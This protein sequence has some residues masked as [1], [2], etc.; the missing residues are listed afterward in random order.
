MDAGFEYA[1][2]IM[3]FDRAPTAWPMPVQKQTHSPLIHLV[4][5]EELARRL[6][7]GRQRRLTLVQAPV[8]FGKTTLVSQW[9]GR[10][11]SEGVVVAWVTVHEDSWTPILL[12]R[13]IAAALTE[14]GIGVE[15]ASSLIPGRAEEGWRY[16]LEALIDA[17]VRAA[18]PIVIFLDQYEHC[19]IPDVDPAI[20]QLLS[21]LPQGVHVAI[22]TRQRPL[23]PIAKLYAEGQVTLV[24]A[25]ELR[26]SPAETSELLQ[27][28]LSPDSI[29][30]VHQLTEGWVV[31]VQLVRLWLTAG[32]QPTAVLDALTDPRQEI[33]HFLAEQ[34]LR[35]LPEDERDFL[36]Q[37]SFLDGFS[38]ALSDFVRQ[39]GDSARFLDAVGH[40]YPLVSAAGSGNASIRVHPLLRAEAR[41]L[42]S[43]RSAA[44]IAALQRRAAE[45]LSAHG[46]VYSAMQHAIA[47]GDT[48]M[49]ADIF[50]RAGALRLF[51]SQG[52]AQLERMLALLPD[53][54][55][56]H[57][58]R[59]VLAHIAML[60]F[61]GKRAEARHAYA[62]LA[63]RTDNFTRGS[64][65]EE[66]RRLRT[67]SL[68]VQMF[69]VIFGDE[70]ISS[71][72]LREF[73]QMDLDTEDLQLR[74]FIAAFLAVSYLQRG[75]LAKAGDAV[76]TAKIIFNDP[77]QSSSSRSAFPIIYQGMLAQIGGH[78][79][80]SLV[81]LD[82]AIALA[83]ETRGT[84]GNVA[85]LMGLSLKAEV[86]L[87]LGH[88]QSAEALL[89]RI[90][91]EFDSTT[92]WFD[93]YAP[94]MRTRYGIALL[95]GGPAE[96]ASAV[97]EFA[98]HVPS[99]SR[100]LRNLAL[101]H[102]TDAQLRS[103]ELDGLE[104]DA[105]RE[106]WDLLRAVPAAASWRELE[107][108]GLALAR[109][110]LALRLDGRAREVLDGLELLAAQ[111]GWRRTLVE[112][113]IL[114]ALADQAA[115][116]R[117]RA[118]KAVQEALRIA[119]ECGLR[120]PFLLA[121]D[122]LVPLLSQ[123]RASS[124]MQEAQGALA[125]ELLHIRA[126]SPG[127]QRLGFLTPRE[128]LVLSQLCH[129]HAN[130]VIARNLGVS[131]N[132]VKTHL[133]SIFRKADIR[134]REQAIE[135]AR[136]HIEGA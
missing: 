29:A 117:E 60:S 37:T 119:G 41:H 36:V 106:A 40:L 78:Q 130:K 26:L 52:A 133:K 25:D 132:T 34:V 18:V 104:L 33:A 57:R 49:A 76:H 112:C 64:D 28:H 14:A 35:V 8:G 80:A 90:D 38:A 103:G 93:I 125:D 84:G 3:S 63:R 46:D 27:C 110:S 61:A 122:S 73:E 124:S 82:A 108:V 99:Q 53:T 50:E 123:E 126:L 45:W 22:T 19:D 86:L 30:R 115:G 71:T 128:Q 131:E 136:R 51:E 92:A 66:V 65:A 97:A 6:E 39:R 4:P 62:D 87:D 56:L 79:E 20:A 94:Q 1:S 135:L 118:A 68:V 134:S 129:G 91:A 13:A 111:R 21:R 15:L 16:D 100:R 102:R 88:V 114:G 5:R 54:A 121:P 7:A 89:Q 43:L 120:G 67:D 95:R 2:G 31:L 113:H 44:S 72:S 11:R 116:M 24:G 74:S 83:E 105:L 59:L 101:A 109:A 107:A 12:L 77:L 10:L 55:K 47:S 58:P 98:A 127:A 81:E 9:L 23:L 32:G 70:T 17:L 75:E 96:A 42:L 85:F 69:F 48:E